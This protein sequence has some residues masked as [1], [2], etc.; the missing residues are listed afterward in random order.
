ME[1]L[2]IYLLA[3]AA[4]SCVFAALITQ[5]MEK[6][7]VLESG[8]PDFIRGYLNNLKKKLE[9]SRTGINLQ[10]YFT[11]KIG[12]PA[13]LAAA[14]YFISDD[15]TLMLVFI[16]FGFLAP[17]AAIT[18]KR[19]SENKKFEDRFVRALAQM[20]ASLHSGLTVEVAID[21]V[22]SCELLSGSIR[23][24]FRM[25]SS[26]LKLG[27][28]LDEVFFEYA[29]KTGSKDVHDVATAITIMNE[30]GGDAGAAIEKLQKNIEDRLL[31]R[32]KRESMMTESKLIAVFADVVPLAILA[33]TYLLMPDTI[34]KYFESP[35]M[36]A[37]FLAVI[38]VMLIG[39]AVVHKMLDNKVDA[40]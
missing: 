3:A 20:A 4:I 14:S 5:A 35:E 39:S 21:S 1:F 12:T 34:A 16:V 24:D 11:L 19:D 18:L 8:T 7:A 17:D 32:K 31:Y 9:Q 15:R 30:L 2:H 37:V 25:L 38:T 33:G 10:Q 22:V 23:D 36:T 6:K 13:I 29:E 40:S 26:R 28:P 27:F